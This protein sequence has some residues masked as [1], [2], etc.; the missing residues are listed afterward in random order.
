MILSIILVCITSLLVGYEL[1]GIY[2]ARAKG[3]TKNTTRIIT[4]LSM[5]VLLIILLLQVIYFAIKMSQLS[6]VIK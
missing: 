6:V 1:Y 4:H 5:F 2:S 3:L